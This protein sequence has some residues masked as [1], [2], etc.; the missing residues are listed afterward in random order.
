MGEVNFY[1][2]KPEASKKSLIYL[3]FRYNGEKLVFSFGQN[4]NP[5]NW[6]YE[7]QRV[8]SNTQTTT[9]GKHSLNDLLDNL[10]K[11]SQSAYNNEI[12]NGVPKPAT[13]RRYL[14]DFM[15]QNDDAG[16]DKPNLFKLMDRFIDNEIKH[17]GRNKAQNTIKTY[18]TLKGHLQEFEHIKKEKVNFHAITID[19]YYRYVEFLRKRDQY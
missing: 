17:K 15:N 1:L 8:K 2:K 12:K 16:P 13:L 3:Q 18:K 6:N 4:I 9:D 14:I 10:E 5:K 19:F 7:K 11:V